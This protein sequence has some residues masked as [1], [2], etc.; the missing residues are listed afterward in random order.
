MGQS[1]TANTWREVTH[2]WEVLLEAIVENYQALA[3]FVECLHFVENHEAVTSLVERSKLLGGK[4][5]RRHSTTMMT[6]NGEGLC[7]RFGNAGTTCHAPPF[8][9]GAER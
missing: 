3:Y 5:W 2:I 6:G 4:A 1:G 7:N 8:R 9:H